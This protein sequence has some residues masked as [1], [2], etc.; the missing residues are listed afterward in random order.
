[1]WCTQLQNGRTNDG[2]GRE[3]SETA[4][5]EWRDWKNQSIL[6]SL[7]SLQSSQQINNVLPPQNIAVNLTAKEWYWA[8]H[9]SLWHM[10]NRWQTQP[11]FSYHHRLS[12]WKHSGRSQELA[13][14]VQHSGPRTG[15]TG[16]T[17]TSFTM[18][19][20]YYL[21][22][23]K[24]AELQYGKGCYELFTV[25]QRS[26]QLSTQCVKRPEPEADYSSPHRANINNECSFTFKSPVQFHDFSEGLYFNHGRKE[27]CKAVSD[28]ETQNVI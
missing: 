25:V 12:L 16:C 9:Y 6:H 23:N 28:W 20:H 27:K 8:I 1:M 11:V 10:T 26:T 19:S 17:K 2:S 5:K 18:F 7:P 15:P 4:G 3:D 14:L 13:R 21:V 24:N 22:R